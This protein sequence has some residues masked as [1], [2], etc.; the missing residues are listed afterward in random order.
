MYMFALFFFFWS[1]VGNG[2]F[3]QID[4]TDTMFS[5]FFLQSCA[6]LHAKVIIVFLMWLQLEFSQRTSINF[7]AI[8]ALMHEI[9]LQEIFIYTVF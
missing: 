5:V 3:F 2:N 7:L 4:Q 1:F 8:R 9:C 6:H